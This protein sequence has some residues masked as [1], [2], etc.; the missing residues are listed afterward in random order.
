MHNIQLAAGASIEALTKALKDST[1]IAD[2][3]M[4]EGLAKAT[5]A[6]SG[7]AVSGLTFYDLEVGAKLLY[8]VLTPLR[9]AIPRVSG[10]GGIQAKLARNHCD[11]LRQYFRRRISG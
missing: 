2:P 4:P 11:Q 8:P 9:N 1:K 6:Q 7:S 5:F 3:L 10:R